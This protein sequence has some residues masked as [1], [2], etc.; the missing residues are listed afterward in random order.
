MPVTIPKSGVCRVDVQLNAKGTEEVK[1][2]IGANKTKTDCT[3]EL[4]ATKLKII[5]IK[6]F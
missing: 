1:F 4:I 5:L 2:T 6:C 3:A